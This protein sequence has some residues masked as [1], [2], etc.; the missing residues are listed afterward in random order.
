M[1]TLDYRQSRE[2]MEGGLRG[3]IVCFSPK[4]SS[5]QEGVYYLDAMMRWYPDLISHLTHGDLRCA[6]EVTYL[7]VLALVRLYASLWKSIIK[8]KRF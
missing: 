4:P 8:N 7:Y 3:V 5:Y 2:M 6:S 1:I